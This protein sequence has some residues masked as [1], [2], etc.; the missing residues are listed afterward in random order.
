M[1]SR[2]WDSDERGRGVAD[3]RARLP[4]IQQLAELAGSDDW[5][6]EDPEAH[7]LPGLRERLEIAG[8][9]IELVEVDP[10]GALRV[11]LTSPSKQSRRELRQSVWSILGVLPS[12]PR[13]CGRRVPP[14]GSTSRS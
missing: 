2:R 12:S 6:A 7:L 10:D 5:V 13:S 1:T 8:L 11:R 4:P 9:T 3:A 14:L